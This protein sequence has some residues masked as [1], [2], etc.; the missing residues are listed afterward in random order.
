[1]TH[2]DL[3]FHLQAKSVYNDVSILLTLLKQF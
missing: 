2:P 1:M 3:T